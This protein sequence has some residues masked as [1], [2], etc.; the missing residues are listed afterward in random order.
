LTDLP[1]NTR[2]GSATF[3]FVLSP[4]LSLMIVLLLLLVVTMVLYIL[5]VRLSYKD[6]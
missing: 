3:L 1:I 6:F 2:P 4:F 5:N